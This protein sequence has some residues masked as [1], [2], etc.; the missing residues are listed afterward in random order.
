MPEQNSDYVQFAKDKDQRELI[1]RSNWEGGVWPPP[2]RMGLL[3]SRALERPH[4][5]VTA[6]EGEEEARRHVNAGGEVDFDEHFRVDWYDRVSA[7][8]ISDEDIK[9]M[10]HVARGAAYA[11]EEAS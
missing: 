3:M 10:T 1:L 2:E 11:L 6:P 5:I 8:Q 7:S 4:M 9:T